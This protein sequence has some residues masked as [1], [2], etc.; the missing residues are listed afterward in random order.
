[1]QT[2]L[3]FHDTPLILEV[4]CPE[5]LSLPRL[6]GLLHDYWWDR[7]SGSQP[8]RLHLEIFDGS[9]P[10][11]EEFQ[12][13]TETLA[14]AE[15]IRFTFSPTRVAIQLGH[16][17]ALVDFSKSSATVY[18]DSEFRHHTSSQ[19][20]TFWLAIL[21][22]LL[23]SQRTYMMHAAG[24]TSANGE[25]VIFVA[26]GGSGKSTLTLGLI[27]GGWPFLS[28]DIL[29]LRESDSSIH[30]YAGRR[31]FYV[32]SERAD[33]YRDWPFGESNS[34]DREGNLR[35][36]ILVH[37]RYP[38]QFR[39]HCHP[40]VLIL[41]RIIREPHSRLIP[42]ERATAIKDLLR[43]SS[44]GLTGRRILPGQLAVLTRLVGQC[45]VFRLESGEDLHR[46]P[47]NFSELLEQAKSTL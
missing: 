27:G 47:A 1:M 39:A 19:L 37:Q 35:Q 31:S 41:P 38:S 4:I 23:Q 8:T 20:S 21:V 44:I 30:A 7:Y 11:P 45:R 15:G 16:T 17:S 10:L 40:T 25:G 13:S 36:E 22:S 33:H 14:L 29:F 9:S 43:E 18:M 34:P 6:K 24:L 2:R 28:D 3:A 32:L 5:H 46:C 42:L 12:A 26:T